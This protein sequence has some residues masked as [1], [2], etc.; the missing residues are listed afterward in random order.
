RSLLIQTIRAAIPNARD[1]DGLAVH[2][3]GAIPELLGRLDAALLEHWM[4]GFHDPD[5]ARGPCDSN[6]IFHDSVALDAALL[7]PCRI[8][9]QNLRQRQVLPVGKAATQSTSVDTAVERRQGD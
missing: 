2:E 6:G 9:R 4:R 8:A 5:V 3:P 1:L 7:R